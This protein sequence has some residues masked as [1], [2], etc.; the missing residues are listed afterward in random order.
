MKVG[1]PNLPPKSQYS[2]RSIKARICVHFSKCYVLIYR[3]GWEWGDRPHC[4]WRAY[5]LSFQE[6]EAGDHMREP[7]LY[8]ENLIQM[9]GG[10]GGKE[11]GG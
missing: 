2:I 8:N 5:H 10:K 11:R 9:K 7:E 1:A 6:V 4:V 3:I